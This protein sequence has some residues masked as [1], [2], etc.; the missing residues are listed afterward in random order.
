METAGEGGPY[1][2]ALLAGYMLWREEGEA[3][4][5]YLE[6]KVFKKAKSQ[7]LTATVEE[8]EGFESFIEI[9]EKGL[10]IEKEAIKKL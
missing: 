9:Y 7:T 8:I 10:S 2:M 5:D 3:L 6:N 4:E 1:G